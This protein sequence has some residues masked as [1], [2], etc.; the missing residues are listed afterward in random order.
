MGLEALLSQQIIGLAE[1]IDDR[2]ASLLQAGS[3]ISLTYDDTANTLTIASSGG[4]GGGGSAKCQI[5]IFTSS[6]TWTKPTG[7]QMVMLKLVSGGG[8]GG[9]GRRGATGTTRGGGG[10]GGPA[11]HGTWLIPASQLGSTE[12]VTVGAGGTGGAAVTADNTNGNAGS[13]GGASIFGNY[14]ANPGQPGAGGATANALGGNTTGRFFTLDAVWIGQ[15][16]TGGTGSGDSQGSAVSDISTNFTPAPGG[17][18]GSITSGNAFLQGRNGGTFSISA[19]GLAVSNP[20]AGGRSNM[21]G[22]SGGD[23]TQYYAYFGAG[24]GGGYGGNTQAGTR[25]GNGIYGSGGGGGGGSTNGFDSGAGGN[26]GDGIVIV[27]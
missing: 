1:S 24:G 6:G 11:F 27:V 7:C 8:G 17:G 13:A 23:A 18:G 19:N 15:V 12:S 5:D 14:R 21:E 3:N 22:F 10:G 26:G 16:T 25:G 20:S 2:V 9:S 4:G